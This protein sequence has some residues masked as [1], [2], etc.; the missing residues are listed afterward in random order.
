MWW[1][2]DLMVSVSPTQARPNATTA[3]Y[4]I[5]QNK[6][7]DFTF[8]LLGDPNIQ[9]PRTLQLAPNAQ[10][11]IVLA[12]ILLRAV[13]TGEDTF[14]FVNP[15][16]TGDTIKL[17]YIDLSGNVQTWSPVGFKIPAAKIIV[18]GEAVS[19]LE[20]V[21]DLI[22]VI[23]PTTKVASVQL[24][25]DKIVNKSTTTDVTAQTP[26]VAYK[27]SL[28]FDSTCMS[29]VDAEGPT[30]FTFNLIAAGQVDV[31]APLTGTGPQPLA[32]LMVRISGDRTV[33]CNMNL[34]SAEIDQGG[35]AA[36]ILP[37][38]PLSTI[39]LQRGN[40]DASPDSTPSNTSVNIG[41]ALSIVLFTVNVPSNVRKYA[42][43]DPNK[44][45]SEKC[46]LGANAA[47][48]RHD[49]TAGDKVTIADA[50]LV[51]QCTVFKKN[52]LCP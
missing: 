39:A 47:S 2:F 34:T 28:A 41:D 29:I 36:K 38:T 1:A 6:G 26:L 9:T 32:H 31:Q 13:T 44:P 23:D 27:A 20:A 25:L 43:N 24:R 21:T 50:L 49:G 33:V 51:V 10:G 48:V 8:T 15:S 18:G 42:C 12:R 30:G 4:F 7:G 3:Q 37:T 22:Q 11:D 14:S 45:A 46:L 40:A 5:G 19:D 35:G 17:V 52:A 16:G